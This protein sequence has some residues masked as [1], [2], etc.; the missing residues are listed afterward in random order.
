MRYFLS[1]LCTVFMQFGF[2]IFGMVPDEQEQYSGLPLHLACWSNDV[3][4]LSKLLAEN[5]D[6]AGS[7]ALVQ[8]DVNAQDKDGNTPLHIACMKGQEACLDFLLQQPG[9]EVN[10]ENIHGETPFWIACDQG[11]NSLIIKLLSSSTDIEVNK[12]PQAPFNDSQPPLFLCCCHGDVSVVEQLM[13]YKSINLEAEHNGGYYLEWIIGS[14][15]IDCLHWLLNS[16]FVDSLKTSNFSA[17]IGNCFFDEVMDGTLCRENEENLMELRVQIWRELI[18]SLDANLLNTSE[19]F[20]E[21]KNL[22]LSLCSMYY[23]KDYPKEL[24]EILLE[25]EDLDINVCDDNDMTAIDY[26]FKVNRGDVMRI[27]LASRNFERNKGVITGRLSEKLKAFRSHTSESQ[28]HIL[29]LKLL[30][31]SF[32][33]GGIK[34]LDVEIEQ[35]KQCGLRKKNKFVVRFTCCLEKPIYPVHFFTTYVVHQGPIY[36]FPCSYCGK[37]F[38]SQK[39]QVGI[40][41]SLQE[42]QNKRSLQKR[43][44]ENSS[45]PAPKRRYGKDIED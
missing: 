42:A 45:D 31:N 44:R 2:V 43:C 11:H 41:T 17:R 28:V 36:T 23:K 7:F 39:P 21:N 15:A 19:G 9:I 4:E 14:G 18:N 13:S 35:Q 26:L 30:I 6:R 12:A 34:G 8:Y 25:A 29:L 37:S 27:L 20:S 33:R 32:L 40:S 16:S 5:A 38:S 22:L 1:L 24:L 10:R 3:D